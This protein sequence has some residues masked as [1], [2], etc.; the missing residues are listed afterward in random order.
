MCTKFDGFLLAGSVDFFFLIFSVFL[1]FCYYLPL[2]R[3][4]PLHVYKLESPPP[5]N[6][7]CVVLLKLVL[8]KKILNDPTSFYIFVIISPLKRSGHL[9]EQTWIPFTQG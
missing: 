5:N 4:N 6:D 1:L 2:E 8:E 3:G 7:L 9:F